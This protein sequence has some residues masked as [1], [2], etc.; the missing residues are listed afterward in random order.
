MQTATSKVENLAEVLSR[1]M[2]LVHGINGLNRSLRDI[3]IKR[4]RMKEGKKKWDRV[5]DDVHVRVCVYVR[6]RVCGSLR[7]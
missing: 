7:K 6:V 5:S 4:E 3:N 2:T 1:L